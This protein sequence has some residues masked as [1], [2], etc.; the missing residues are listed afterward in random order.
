MPLS[1]GI[2]HIEPN[3][4]VFVFESDKPGP[5]ALIQ[6]GIH[7]DEIAGDHPWRCRL[8]ADCWN[9]WCLAYAEQADAQLLEVDAGLAEE[10]LFEF[11][12]RAVQA[13]YANR[14]ELETTPEL[15]PF[16]ADDRFRFIL[17]AFGG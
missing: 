14:R 16:R 10:R 6:G 7:G 9:E 5:T 12:G 3:I 2:H 15:D 8:V 1:T 11:L 17:E 13:G 4:P